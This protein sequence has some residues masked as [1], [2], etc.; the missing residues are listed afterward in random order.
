MKRSIMLVFLALLTFNGLAA[1]PQKPYE[2]PGVKVIP[3]K[4]SGENR[5]YELLV[6]LPQKYSQ[7]KDRAYPVIYF[8]DAVWHIEFLSSATEFLMEEAILVGISWQKDLNTA[9]VEKQQAHFSRFRD[10]SIKPSN[11]PDIQAK[12]QFGQAAKHL[13][14]IRND[15]I[16]YIEN[17]YRTEKDNRSYLG[18]SLGGLFGAYVLLAQ[19]DTF[20]NY[21]L[22]SPSIWSNMPIFEALDANKGKQRKTLNANVFISHGDQEKELAER[23]EHFIAFLNNKNDA[24]LSLKQEVIE[25]THQSAFPLTGVRSLTWLSNLNTNKQ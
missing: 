13:A 17:N 22:G 3:I 1:T 9:S 14:F 21:I 10:Y 15:V 6:K 2:M 19:P 16:K 8:T 18:Y 20:K 11:K 24:S 7:N 4:D 12:Y 25:G 23:I 5:Q